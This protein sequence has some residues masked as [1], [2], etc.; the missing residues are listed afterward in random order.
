MHFSPPLTT[1]AQRRRRRPALGQQREACGEA[2]AVRS[3]AETP[4]T[5]ANPLENSTHPVHLKHRDSQVVPG[6]GLAYWKLDDKEL[7]HPLPDSL[8]SVSFPLQQEASAYPPRRT[9][10]FTSAFRLSG[11]SFPTQSQPLPLGGAPKDGSLA[12][13]SIGMFCRRSD[14]MAAA[15]PASSPS[16]GQDPCGGTN[17]RPY[18]MEEPSPAQLP[19]LPRPDPWLTTPARAYLDTTAAVE[20]P[21]LLS[22]ARQSMRE[23]TSRHIADLRAYYEAEISSLKQQLAL[24]KQ[25]PSSDVKAANQILKDR[26]SELE[27]RVAETM[28]RTKELEEHNL[29]LEKQLTE[30][31]ER[32]DTT[33]ATVTALQRQ[34]E[35]S[36]QSEREKEAV[37]EQLRA[38]LQQLEQ[39]YRHAYRASDDRDTQSQR[40]HRMLQDLLTEYEDLGKDHERVKDKLVSAE[41]RLFDARAEISEL[42][43]EG[44]HTGQPS[45]LPAA[46]TTRHHSP[47]EGEGPQGPLIGE[48]PPRREALLAPAIKS[49]IQLEET[50]ATEGRALQRPDSQGSRTSHSHS[51]AKRDRLVAPLSAKSSPKRCPSE[52]YSTAFGP[53]RP[54][55]CSTHTW[56]D[57]RLDERGLMSSSP[58][59]SSNAKK[60]LQ[61]SEANHQPSNGGRG[62]SSGTESM[63]RAMELSCEEQGAEG[64]EAERAWPSD[65]PLSYQERLHSLADMERLFDGLTRE[66]QQI[67][68]ALSRIPGSGGREALEERL[69]N[70]NREL[71]SIRMT[72]KKFH[73][74]R[75]SANI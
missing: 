57:V 13:S 60:K 72:L 22:L 48:E 50:R 42:K 33:V 70:I 56:F 36:K 61:V 28:A 45:D 74:L 47:P 44:P 65:T 6:T 3:A 73:I 59:H 23:K 58:S 49:L 34:L 67:E 37:A 21:V 43:R 8:T 66:K 25:P 14:S 12:A 15:S 71:G 52:N 5:R 20:D 24:A 54:W 19:A 30:R 46:S 2:R 39:A 40:E 27:R 51:V 41:D 31:Q 53:S 75:S 10:S 1:W 26:C 64:S 7:F 68:A 63:K 18:H 16:D 38:R 62:G 35:E 69:E 55:Q 32:Y 17:G 4:Q 9:P 11:P 29:L